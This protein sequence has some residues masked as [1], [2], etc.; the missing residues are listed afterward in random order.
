[1]SDRAKKV[2]ELTQLVVAANNDLLIIEDV[3]ANT[4]KSI[5]LTNLTKVVVANTL[6]LTGNNT[7]TNSSVPV[8]KGT[9]FYDTN[10]LYIAVE[11][12]VLKRVSLEGF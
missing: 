1:M 3:S 8:V 10:F 9:L 12:N 4:T 7:P 2:S 11:N 6:I 5:T